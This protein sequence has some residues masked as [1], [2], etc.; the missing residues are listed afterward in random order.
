MLL[1]LLRSAHCVVL[2]TEVCLKVRARHQTDT[3]TTVMVL[4]AELRPRT[5][6]NDRMAAIRVLKCGGTIV[7]LEMTTKLVVTAKTL[8]CI[9]P[10]IAKGE[11]RDA[12]WNWRVMCTD[13]CAKLARRA[14]S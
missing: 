8:G 10:G 7:R 5:A 13:D 1:V 11:R 2:Q 9:F 4:A 6:G 12:V 3:R 14:L